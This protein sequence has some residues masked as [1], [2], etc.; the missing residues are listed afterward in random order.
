MNKITKKALSVLF[1]AIF[2]PVLANCA[3]SD[4]YIDSQETDTDYV[5]ENSRVLIP[6]RSIFEKMGYDVDYDEY[7]KTAYIFGDKVITIRSGE[8]GFYCDGK[9]VECDQSQK[10]ID[11]RFYIPLRKITEALDDYSV[12]WNE[13]TKSVYITRGADNK[14]TE[15]IRTSA[16]K[17]EPDN[18]ELEKR[19]FEL[20]N[21]E[22]AKNGLSELKWSDELA[23]FAREHSK[24]M[25]ERN[26]FG[27]TD[28]QGVTFVDRINEA[29]IRYSYCAENVAAGS[30]TAEG[31][32]EQWLGSSGH[33]ANILSS[34][35][36][37]I[38]VGLCYDAD[39]DYGYYWTQCFIKN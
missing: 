12:E 26:Y 39:S 21:E 24:D 3:Y 2:I 18:S 32:M 37:Y 20:V 35:T 14:N 36:E 33:R 13:K 9:W 30:T 25:A 29:N 1:A 22:R 23:G 28:P 4:I 31:V 16:E 6:V 27:H 15:E 11:G 8:T 7:T 5:I 38:G 10:T 17:N 34:E 19:V